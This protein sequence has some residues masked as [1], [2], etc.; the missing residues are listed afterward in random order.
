MGSG[1]TIQLTMN[2]V[3]QIEFDTIDRFLFNKMDLKI[4]RIHFDHP[5][6]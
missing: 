1:L 2:T 3:K 5:Y 4:D 6:N